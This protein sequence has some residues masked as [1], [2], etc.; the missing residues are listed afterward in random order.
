MGIPS[1][2][3]ICDELSDAPANDET[4]RF[5]GA[6]ILACRRARKLHGSGKVTDAHSRATADKREHLQA[7]TICQYAT[8]TPE[9]NDLHVSYFAKCETAVNQEGSAKG[10]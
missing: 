7:R 2:K 5:Q 1:S 9:R 4:P 3:F 10:R 6:K 8:D